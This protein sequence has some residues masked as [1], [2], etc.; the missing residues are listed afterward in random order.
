MHG[1]MVETGDTVPLETEFKVKALA[2]LHGVEEQGDLGGVGR[3]EVWGGEDG[4]EV[5]RTRGG[6]AS[7]LLRVGEVGWST[8]GGFRSE[9]GGWGEWEQSWRELRGGV[10]R[11]C[12]GLKQG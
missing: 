11:A 7:E 2:A 4:A 3:E 8:L 6:A 1:S 5:G 12:G 9:M 10:G